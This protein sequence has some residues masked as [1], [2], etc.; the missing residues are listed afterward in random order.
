MG[1]INNDHKP[2]VYKWPP[3][4]PSCFVVGRNSAIQTAVWEGLGRRVSL[5]QHVHAGV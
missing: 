5:Y 4:M 3:K 2:G 1:V